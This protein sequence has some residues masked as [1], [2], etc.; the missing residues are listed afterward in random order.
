MRHSTQSHIEIRLTRQAK[1]N[2]P[3]YNQYGPENR[4]IEDLV[5][6]ADETQRNGLGSVIPEFEF[7]QPPHKRTEL[8]VL[9]GGQPTRSAILHTLI[10][11]ERGIEFWRQE[12]EEEIEEVDAQRVR[13]WR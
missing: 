5:P 6:A 12:G 4:Q 7:R 11:L 2:Q 8:V 13:D 1:Q 9:L 3:V 10:L